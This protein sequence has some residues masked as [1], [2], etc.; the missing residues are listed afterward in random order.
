M[1]TLYKSVF[2]IALGIVSLTA[3]AQKDSTLIRQVLLERDYNPTLQDASKVNTQPSIYSPVIKAKELKFVSTVP[4]ITL[5]NNKLGSAAPSDIN[6]GVDFSKKRGYLVLGAGNNSN[7]EGAFGYRLVNGNRDRLDVFAT[8]SSTSANV[9]YI[10][11]DLYTMDEA[12]AKYSASKINLKYQHMFDP[13]VLWFDASFYNTSYNYYGNP[14]ISESVALS[15]AAYPFDLDS[16]QN[17]DV[18]SIGA[19]LKSSDRNQG[20]LKYKGGVRYQNFK[21]KYGIYTN[22]DGPKGGQLDLDADFYTEFG[23]D[24]SIGVKGFIMNQSFS[25][26]S[27]TLENAFHGFTNI[28]ATPYIKFQGGNWDA[29]LGVNVS[30]MLDAKTK[31]M[32]SPNVKA[33]IHIND[34]NTFYGEV[35]GG[36]NNNTYLDILQENRYVNPIARV[37][38]S[39]T[40]F[41]ARLGFRSGVVSG[42]EFDIF[43][44]YKK[45]DKDHLYL[46]QS[47]YDPSS[48]TYIPD[49]L[50]WGNVGT[51]LYANIGTGHVGGLLKTKLIPYTDL[52]AK[53]TAYFYD[54]KYVNGN[55]TL[56]DKDLYSEKKAWGRPTFTAELC[57]D[58]KPIDKL[59]FSLNY[60]YA[61]GRKT[62]YSSYMIPVQEVIKMKDINELNFRGEYQVTDWL[63][64]NARVNNILF[65]KYE[66]QYGYA[67][68]GFNVLGGLSFKF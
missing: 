55:V 24:R 19:G 45:T 43:A 63:S 65:Q 11:A 34:V 46:A 23:S 29:D 35:T 9:D 40:L 21:S 20:I 60:L 3:T 59:T 47:L 66:L 41:D 30:G 12:K 25:G 48:S 53:I 18:F 67:L 51:P 44:G 2:V 31:F 68:Q 58:I 62:V 28:T 27:E 15:P 49:A 26:K 1:K 38:Y 6:T 14:F 7:L 22:E 36:V 10:N 56:I 52:S 33:A 39:K 8:H 4:Q 5:T 57:A 54:V 13:S 50:T 17:V 64:V 37:E 42:F 32:A 16:R 61:G